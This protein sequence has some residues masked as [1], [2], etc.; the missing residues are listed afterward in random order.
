MKK[1]ATQYLLGGHSHHQERCELHDKVYINPGSLGLA[2]DGRGKR[3]EFAIMQGSEE[4]WKVKFYSI[5][6]DIHEFLRDFRKSGLDEYGMVLNKAI[7]KTLLT[8]E[9][10]FYHAVCE[11]CKLSE[12]PLHEIEENIWLKVEKNLDL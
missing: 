6:Y 12:K 5:E 3:A 7:K 4:E 9:N 2:I 8:G 10:Y 11:A 1:L